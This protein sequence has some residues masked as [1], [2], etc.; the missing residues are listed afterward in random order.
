[1][2]AGGAVRDWVGIPSMTN[3]AGDAVH[4]IQTEYS[5]FTGSFGAYVTTECDTE[6]ELK[7]AMAWIDWAYTE[8]GQMYWNFGTEGDSYEMV[9]GKA[10][11]TDKMWKD[12]RGIA[13]ALRDYT[14]ASAMPVGVQ[15]EEF[16]RAKNDPACGDS[17]DLWVTNQV[18]ADY[19]V[20][21]LPHTAEENATVTDLNTAL[22][23]YV[24]EMAIKFITGQESL[25]NFDAFLG[26][27]DKMNL[28][29]V[30]KIK[31][32]AYQRFLGN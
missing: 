15:L 28:A 6:E 30:L 7:A 11:F 19:I 14:G 27:L 3:E 4:W 10:T 16:V 5:T 2:A 1:M 22:N 31:N 18:A 17:V 23:T 20:P 25:D 21:G 32:D 26:Q 12:E 29:E 8:E 9:D 24:T 13:Q